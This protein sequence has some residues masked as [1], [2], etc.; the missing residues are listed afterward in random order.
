[1]GNQIVVHRPDHEDSKRK[2]STTDIS[3]K[4]IVAKEQAEIDSIKTSSMLQKGVIEDTIELTNKFS[5][6][7]ENLHYV[8]DSLYKVIANIYINKKPT[9]KAKWFIE[10]EESAY[11]YM[12]SYPQYFE[13]ED[14]K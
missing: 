3:L 7:V 1:M 4:S 13:V 11:D 9:S 2:R 14:K 12:R 10:V 8:A 6:I 5:N